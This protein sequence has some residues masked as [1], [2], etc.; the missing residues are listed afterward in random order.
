MSLADRLAEVRKERGLNLTQAAAELGVARTAYRLWE[1]GAATPAPEHW[2]SVA[3]MCQI[4]LATILR[5][6]GILSAE[7]EEALLKLAAKQ[8]RKGR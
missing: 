4:P 1:K 5:E 7:Q 8:L 2:H 3:Q 6:L